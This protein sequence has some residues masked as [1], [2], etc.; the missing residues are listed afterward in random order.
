MAFLEVSS[1]VV[2]TARKPEVLTKSQAY[3][4]IVMQLLSSVHVPS[5]FDSVTQL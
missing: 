2:M 1:F 4:A 3:R 5:G